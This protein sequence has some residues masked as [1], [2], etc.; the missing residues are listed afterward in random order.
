MT[1]FIYRYSGWIL[2]LLLVASYFAS[3]WYFW[4][5]HFLFISILMVFFLP[6]HFVEKY[7]K[8]WLQKLG[9]TEK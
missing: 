8:P 1:T 9:V 4:G 2:I 5:L 7:R 6:S 3:G